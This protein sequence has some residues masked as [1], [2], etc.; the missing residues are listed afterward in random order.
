MDQLFNIKH[1]SRKKFQ[2]HF[3]VSVHCQ[4]EFPGI[5]INEILEKRESLKSG[6]QKYGEFVEKEVSQSSV[7][8][9]KKD[10]NAM[11][12][13]KQQSETIGLLYSDSARRKEIQINRENLIYSDYKY[14]GFD[15]FIGN[16]KNYLNVVN[17]FLKE[18]PV[19]KIGLRKI[20]HIKIDSN[21]LTSDAL[22]IFNKNL[23][24]LVR[25]GI[26]ELESI[27]ISSEKM[28]IEKDDLSCILQT[29]VKKPN[30]SNSLIASLDFD[31]INKAETDTENA[32]NVLL[33]EMN[34]LHFDLFMWSITPDFI[35]EME[36][37]E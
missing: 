23:F 10:S 9:E 6:F 5:D 12:S 3:L 1:F 33:P 36:K 29:A 4:L 27:K 21:P 26:S 14:E 17:E 22:D 31:L 19:I 28:L 2:K 34:S 35:K 24:S 11:Q 20:N 13:I 18:R 32:V 37:P 25:S 15:I 16:L 7:Q 30:E 8:F